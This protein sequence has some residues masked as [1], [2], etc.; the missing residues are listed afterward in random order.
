LGIFPSI[1]SFSRFLFVARQFRRFT[2]AVLAVRRLI[3]IKI[4]N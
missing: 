2:G 1:S 3:I 4:K